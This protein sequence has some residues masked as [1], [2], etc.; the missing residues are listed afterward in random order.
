MP[1]LVFIRPENT[2]AALAAK[3]EAQ[4]GPVRLLPGGGKIVRMP[5]GEQ[6]YCSARALHDALRCGGVI[7]DDAPANVQYG[8]SVTEQKNGAAADLTARESFVGTNY[9]R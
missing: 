7:I 8:P 2:A 5:N 3:I 1:E 9:H 6:K 4:P